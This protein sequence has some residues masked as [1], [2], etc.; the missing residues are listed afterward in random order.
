MNI[1]TFFSKATAV[2]V[3]LATICGSLTATAKPPEILMKKVPSLQTAYKNFQ[4]VSTDRALVDK[5]YEE[6]EKRFLESGEGVFRLDA[7][8]TCDSN[9]DKLIL[10][11]F[12]NAINDFF[13]RYAHIKSA[14]IKISGIFG[15]Y[16]FTISC[17]PCKPID[18]GK[19]LLAVSNGRPDELGI[20]LNQGEFNAVSLPYLFENMWDGMSQGIYAGPGDHGSKKI[21]KKPE[22]ISTYS[23]IAYVMH[24]ELGHTSANIDSAIF[25]CESPDQEE[26]FRN[27]RDV[28]IGII[29]AHRIEAAEKGELEISPEEFA[30][31][32]KAYSDLEDDFMG[33]FPS[34]APDVQGILNTYPT[35]HQRQM[36]RIKN[37]IPSQNDLFGYP[38]YSF[39]STTSEKSPSE[40]IA[41]I[42]AHAMVTGD[43]PTINSRSALTWLDAL[44]KKCEQFVKS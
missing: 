29:L 16:K 19:N 6:E 15:D 20:T 28:I 4:S 30:R 8:A 36:E 39:L 2:A 21:V 40:Y 14:L 41:E 7:S 42:V 24:H 18:A 33:R 3:S 22:G 11:I 23:L 31:I 1:K 38:I 32:S 13:D 26:F 37:E 17:E 5:Y 10:A 44:N 43:K 9:V 25:L 12:L 34:E 35:F 27:Y